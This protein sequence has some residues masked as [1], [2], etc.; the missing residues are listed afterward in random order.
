[1]NT[2]RIIRATSASR[3][4]RFLKI[5][6]ATLIILYGFLH[7]QYHQWLDEIHK[8]TPSFMSNFLGDRTG[9]RPSPPKSTK[10]ANSTMSTATIAKENNKPKMKGRKRNANLPAPTEFVHQEGVAIVTKIHGPHQ[11]PLVQQSMCLFHHAYNQ[12]LLYDIVVFSAEPIDPDQ[13]LSLQA[14][15]APVQIHVVLDN[16][17]LQ[18]EIAALSP[19][20]RKLFL[21]RCKQ[22]NQMESASDEA[23][24]QNL[25]WFSNCGD[26]RL[27]YNWQAEFRSIHIWNHPALQKYKWMFWMDTDA[28]CTKKWDR[29]PIAFAIH[30]N[31]TIFFDNYPG[32]GSRDLATK[33]AKGFNV[34]LCKTR[35]TPQGEFEFI[36]GTVEDA[37]H[38]EHCNSTQLRS[39]YGFLHITNLDFYRTPAVQHG[40]KSLLGD[41]FLARDPDDQQAVTIPAAILAPERSWDMRKKGIQLDVFH[42]LHIDGK[43][44]EK[45]KGFTQYWKT[46]KLREGMGNAQDVCPVTEAK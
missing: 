10:T 13:V 5:V 29:D 16:Q 4:L 45:V 38:N 1:M 37:I 33:I 30:H 11:W 23:M 18:E 27:A 40:I 8:E 34:T 17:G 32:G 36:L 3:R 43:Q 24:S 41:N 14:L 25:T 39:I 22:H 28:F 9:R 7:V 12:R 44:S 31:L 46:S 35:V 15:V 42:N 2:A 19:H 26:G 6:L 21:D 20:R